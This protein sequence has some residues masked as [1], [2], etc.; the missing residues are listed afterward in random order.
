MLTK[1]KTYSKFTKMWIIQSIRPD[2]IHEMDF[3]TFGKKIM[4]LTRFLNNKITIK[5][6]QKYG[7]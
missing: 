6:I 3:G 5:I 7:N 4:D 2:G 1:S